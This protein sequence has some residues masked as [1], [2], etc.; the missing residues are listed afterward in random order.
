MRW[1]LGVSALVVIASTFAFAADPPDARKSLNSYYA[2]RLRQP[3]IQ[4]P[5]E[6]EV[7]PA[8][9][10]WEAPLKQ[11]AST[12]PDD[13][14]AAAT[15]LRELVSLSLEDERSGKAPWRNTPYWGGGAEVPARDLRRA[16]AEALA[17]AEPCIDKQIERINKWATENAHKTPEQL[18]LDALEEAITEG[19][20]WHRIEER[21][22][23][24]LKAK[25]TRVYDVMKRVFEKDGTDAWT[26][27]KILDLYRKHDAM[28]AK[29]LAPKYLTDK[30]ESLRLAAALIV[31]KTGDKPTARKVL[32]DVVATGRLWSGAA[33]AL[34]E[35]N[36][37]ESRKEL[38]R[39]F[40]NRNMQTDRFGFR[41]MILARC[42]KAGMKEPYQFYSKMLDS[43]D[44][45]HWAYDIVVGFARDDPAIKDI[46]SKYPERKDQSPHLKKWL[47]SHLDPP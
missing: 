35:D 34:L 36:T 38:V 37:P 20:N 21:V 8:P 22:A 9:P 43:A 4:L 6:P 41:G 46:V 17:K 14:R 11:L 28:R 47:R 39:L 29:D 1:L 23:N 44:A 5:D 12:K 42:A 45:E 31:F 25:E 16:V 3:F 13:R 26:R 27:G 32:G 15:Y 30:D 24:L 40:T 2:D 18:A 7:K 33:D 10:P 19:E